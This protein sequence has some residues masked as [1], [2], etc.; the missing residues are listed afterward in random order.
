MGCSCRGAVGSVSLLSD[1]EGVGVVGQD[2]P[3]S[4]D[5]PPLVAFQAGSV[6]PVAAF[7]VADPA[8]LA[9]A[10]APQPACAALGG[11]L[12]AAS[13][14]Y[15]LGV[16]VG[17][18]GVGRPGLEPAI[19]GDLADLDPEPVELGD[20]ARQQCLLGR[21]AQFGRGRQDQTPR[22]ALGVLG[23]LRQLRDEP[24]LRPLAELALADRPG[25]WIVQRHDPILDR[26]VR[27]PADGFERRSSRSGPPS[28]P[29]RRPP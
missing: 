16:K 2:R 23:H 22:A 19:H 8:L 12:L 24:K 9:S 4:P 3:L 15:R 10:V 1:G 25:V 18:R 28:P 20:G 7:E 17:E 5:P 27:H 29:A 13:D 26:I 21:V 6:Q 14:E 11:W